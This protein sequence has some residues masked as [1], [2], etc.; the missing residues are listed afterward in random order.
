MI[1]HFITKRGRRGRGREMKR[2]SRGGK[3]REEKEKEEEKEA[4]ISST[5]HPSWWYARQTGHKC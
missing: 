2:E 3:R 4:V 5:V 1:S